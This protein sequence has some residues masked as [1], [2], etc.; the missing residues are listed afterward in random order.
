MQTQADRS[1]VADMVKGAVAGAV[2][3]WLMDRAGD[4]LYQRE[5]SAVVAQEH[6]ARVDGKDPAHVAAG[7]LA[8]TVGVSLPPEQPHPAGIAVH[9]ALG[10]FPGALYGSLRHRVPGL[11]MGKGLVYGLGFFLLNDEVLNP[12]LGLASGPAAYPWQAHAR[13]VV[14]HAVLGVATDCTLEALDR[15][16]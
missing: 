16:V 3:V 4:I 8:N 11:S 14:A 10:I 9:Y 5:S 7:R 12:L 15:T 1:V 13:G 2:G 6:R